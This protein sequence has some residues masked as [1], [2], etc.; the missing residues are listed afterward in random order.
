MTSR[1]IPLSKSITWLRELCHLLQC[2]YPHCRAEGKDRDSKLGHA[3]VH[4]HAKMICQIRKVLQ[5]SMRVKNDDDAFYVTIDHD[6]RGLVASPTGPSAV[7]NKHT[8]FACIFTAPS[9]TRSALSANLYP[10]VAHRRAHR[11][12]NSGKLLQ[13]RHTTNHRAR[14]SSAMR[15]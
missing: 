12:S 2:G 7:W 14:E 6:G 10:L 4:R 5:I 3:C 15:P 1:K 9:S 11:Q 8:V 13:E